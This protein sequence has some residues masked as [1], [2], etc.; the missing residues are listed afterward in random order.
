MNNK[1]FQLVL[2][3]GSGL[4]GAV[5]ADWIGLPI[6]YLLG[7]MAMAATVSLVSYARSGQRLWFPI[8][9][10]HTFIAIIGTMIGSTFS[11]DA[12]DA[13]P[14]LLVTLGAMVL[15]VAA[16]QLI[17]YTIF[18]RL[19]G[20]DRVTAMY[21]AMPGGLI[22]AVSLGEKAG[23]DA[24]TLTLQHFVRIVLVIVSVPLLFQLVTGETVGSA[25]GQTLEKAP[26]QLT[27]TALFLIL[28]VVG[29]LVGPWLK[30]PAGPLIGPMIVTAVFQA[31]TAVEVN[32][33]VSLMNLAQLVVGSG[34]GANFA[35]STPR[36][37]LAAFGLGAVSVGLTLALASMFAI[38]LEKVV[39][40]SFQ[41]LL[42]SFAPGGVTEMSLVA[43][44]LGIAPILVTTHHLFRIILTVTVAGILTRRASSGDTR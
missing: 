21:A 36:R 2:I 5:L 14:D 29:A 44:S 13:A 23:G 34:L 40:I 31:T 30:L 10:R 39:P 41:A 12:F 22:E 32:G 6:P 20:L 19:G 38:V 8:R 43:L 9:L 3:L 42:I 26:A 1:F 27:D 4:F 35:R 15:F 28:A 16:A 24:E 33:P 25:A 17:N 7:S 37:L 18:R 11:S